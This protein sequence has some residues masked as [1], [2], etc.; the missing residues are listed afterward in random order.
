VLTPLARVRVVGLAFCWL[1]AC[2]GDTVQSTARPGLDSLDVRRIAVGPFEV[3]PA[4][5]GQVPD[6]ASALLGAYLGDAL[7]QGGQ[8]VVPVS[9]LTHA[10]AA[11][12]ALPGRA[13][14]RVW[15]ELARSQFGA[16]V[17]AVGRLDRFRERSGEAMGSAQPASVA[18]DIELLGTPSGEVLWRGR[19]DETQV[20]LTQNVL[21]A[22]RYPGRGTRWLGAKELAKWGLGEV[23]RAMPLAP[24]PSPTA[25]PPQ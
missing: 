21:R 18:F 7:A 23:V 2:A 6:D 24:S 4:L 20:A 12:G 1:G 10:G 22:R 14:R 11:A 13:S 17:L 16:E 19:F 3:A 15:A 9:D 25:A 8:D 5:Q